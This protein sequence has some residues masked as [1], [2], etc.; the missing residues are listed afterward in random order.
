M[1]RRAA[2]V[3]GSRQEP[4]RGGLDPSAGAAVAP[5]GDVRLFRACAELGGQ[6]REAAD[7]E[8]A[9]R[10]AARFASHLFGADR[11]AWGYLEPGRDE[12]VLHAGPEPGGHRGAW[13]EPQLADFARGRVD[14][15][16]PG[17]ALVRL[18]RRHRAWGVLALSWRFAEP[19]WVVRHQL[20]RIGSVINDAIE[21]IESR[22]LAEVR[23]RIDRKIMEQLRPKDLFYQILDG[24]RTLTGYNHSATVLLAMDDAPVL[25][26]KAEQ[27]A[28]RKGRSRRIGL[29]AA[30][31]EAVAESLL[32][33]DV[34]GYTLRS[35]QWSAWDARA[36]GELA[37]WLE[38]SLGMHEAEDSGATEVIVAPLLS[39]NRLVGLLRI[40]AS[41]PGCFGPFEAQLVTAFLP[42]VIVAIQNV[43]RTERLQDQVLESERKH[44]MAE[45]ARGVAHDVRN[46]LGA[47]LPLIQQLRHDLAE[48]RIDPRTMDQDLEQIERS[49]ATAT[50]IFQG[51]LNFARRASS[52]E[53]RGGAHLSHAIDNALAI[54]SERLNR[55]GVDLHR[56]IEH[57]LAALP[58]RQTELERVVLN[59]LSNSL[60]ALAL[61][62]SGAR[63][64]IRA[65]TRKPEAGVVLEISDN[66]AGV[67]PDRLQQVLEPFYTTKPTGNGLGLAICRSI[68]WQAGGQI[69]L[70]SPVSQSPDGKGGLGTRVTVSLPCEPAR[71][72]P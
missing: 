58:L 31:P 3:E 70:E 41:T 50:R 42:H 4:E 69:R 49:A 18:K 20:T 22:R 1:S 44:A 27:L 25:E 19:T 48:G 37:T 62:G 11:Y 40:A 10:S 57:E 45:L 8:R 9:V 12:V 21:H 7:V 66:G 2:K 72:G 29:C 51:M 5:L 30:V 52:E 34:G 32:R 33:G 39:G 17:M 60:D 6:L 56:D 14:G 64:E 67:P 28:W 61:T 68:V 16:V 36:S 13:D 23:A 54:V 59:L 63:I 43:R 24:I 55:T 47:V 26:L 71:P 65:R 46:A 35:G 15:A 38:S 53:D